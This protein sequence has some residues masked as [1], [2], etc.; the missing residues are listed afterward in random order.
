[1]GSVLGVRLA[2]RPRRVRP[3]PLSWMRFPLFAPISSGIPPFRGASRRVRPRRVALGVAGRQLP[4]LRRLCGLDNPDLSTFPHPGGELFPDQRNSPSRR[5]RG[6]LIFQA[7]SSVR[8]CAPTA[9]ASSTSYGRKSRGAPT[10]RPGVRGGCRAAS[11]DHRRESAL[12][13]MRSAFGSKERA[14]RSRRRLGRQKKAQRRL[15]VRAGT[16]R[17]EDI[18]TRRTG[19]VIR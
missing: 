18:V 9:P 15:A 3:S 16:A 19:A 17:L 6:G 10:R 12:T 1:M 13:P 2:A 5:P 7:T 14:E 4:G 11:S 8:N